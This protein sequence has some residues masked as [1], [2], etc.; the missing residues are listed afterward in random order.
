MLMGMGAVYIPYMSDPN[1]EAEVEIIDSTGD[2]VASG[3][4]GRKYSLMPSEYYVMLGS[5]AHKQKMV[6]PVVVEENTITP[7]LPD[8]CGLTIDVVDENNYPF[9]G[10]YELARIDKFVPFGRAFGRD[11]DLGEKVKGLLNN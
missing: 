7:L 8:W 5:G 3:K 10:E 4:T 11:P 2:V 6:K 1:L 9:R